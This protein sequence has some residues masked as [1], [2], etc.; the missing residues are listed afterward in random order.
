MLSNKTVN[1]LIYDRFFLEKTFNTNTMLLFSKKE[2]EWLI[3]FLKLPV[4]AS[5]VDVACGSGRHLKAFLDLGYCPYG[6]DASPDW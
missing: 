2:I 6:I 3:G 4:D 1:N 5:V